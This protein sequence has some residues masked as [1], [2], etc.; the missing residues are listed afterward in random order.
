MKLSIVIP[1]YN[2]ME[3]LPV[4][5][6]EIDAALR[7]T[8]IMFEV[9]FIDDGSTDG[10]FFQIKEMHRKD[11]RVHGI[12][13]RTNCGKAS[14]LSAGFQAAQGAIIITMDGDL[15][16]D[17]KEI[18]R[19]LEKIG[20]GF[21]LV[22]GWKNQRVDSFIKNKT[23]L[24]FNSVTNRISKVYLHDFNCGFKA[25]RSEIAKSLSLHG[26]LRRYVPVLV[27][28]EGFTVTEL[29]IHHR[30]RSF[31]TTKYGARR[32]I[33]GYL[34]LITVLLVTKYRTKPLHF[35]GYASLQLM[36]GGLLLT[37]VLTWL[38]YSFGHLSS[39]TLLWFATFTELF[40]AS[41]TLLGFGLLGELFVLEYPH[42]MYIA[43][44]C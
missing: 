43:E 18:P 8:G 3:S 13:F 2:E 16:D 25:Y 21:D 24:L 34:D 32:F 41:M 12:R 33:N 19:F 36:F 20:E 29:P 1:A 14:A 39:I 6:Q 22:S 17:P 4:L 31:G 9:I 10:T 26:E 27:A 44:Q 23:S 5:F 11:N 7:P 42:Q 37:L 35:F 38:A 30:K 28:A 15:Q 40:C